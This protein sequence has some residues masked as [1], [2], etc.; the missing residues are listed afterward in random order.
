[1]FSTGDSRAPKFSHPKGAKVVSSLLEGELVDW[2]VE[3]FVPC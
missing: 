2:S 3:T 1:M